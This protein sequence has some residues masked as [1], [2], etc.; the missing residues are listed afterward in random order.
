MIT[1][2]GTYIDPCQATIPSKPTPTMIAQPLPVRL[3][4][5]ARAHEMRLAHV[6]A[7]VSVANVGTP[8]RQAHAAA[9]VSIRAGVGRKAPL[10]TIKAQALAWAEHARRSGAR[11]NVERKAAEAFTFSADNDLAGFN[12]PTKL[13]GVAVGAT[14][15]AL[16]ILAGER[17]RPAHPV[18]L[19]RRAEV[20]GLALYLGA[21]FLGRLQHKHEGWVRSLPGFP[22][23][24]INV[25][26]GTADAPTRGL[27]VA[28]AVW[29][30]LPG[31]AAPEPE[32]TDAALD[33]AAAEIA[34]ERDARHM[35]GEG[36]APSPAAPRRDLWGE[37][38]GWEQ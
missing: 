16:A 3:D 36:P 25:T 14:Q 11:F 35:I 17:P 12:V 26:G 30:A 29:H 7:R 28:L 31:G 27:N 37:L 2:Y 20:D 33:A 8:Y 19:R 9:L 32:P 4:R 15:D 24:A 21:D 34:A 1:S 5:L 22:V 10:A 18:R 13:V 38:G 23:G 6:A